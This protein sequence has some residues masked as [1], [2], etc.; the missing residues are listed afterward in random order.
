M[1]RPKRAGGAAF[2]SKYRLSGKAEPYRTVRRQS[3]KNDSRQ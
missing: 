3:R 1:P 2:Q